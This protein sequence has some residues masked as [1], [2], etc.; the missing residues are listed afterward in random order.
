MTST[1]AI[2]IGIDPLYFLMLAPA[3]LLA[4]WAQWRVHSAFANAARVP[5]ASGISGAETAHMIMQA[6]GVR[7]VRI[8]LGQGT[9]SDHYDPRHKVVRLSPDVYQGRSAAALGI[10]AHE[11]GHVMQEKAGYAPLAIRN[12]IVPLASVGGQLGGLVFMIGFMLSMM[13]RGGS[14]VGS[15]LMIGA[16]GLFSLFVMFQLINLP[17]E[18][19]ASRRAKQW[20]SSSGL[21]SEAEAPHVHRVL[22]AAAWTYVAATLM[23][24]LTLAYYVLRAVGSRRE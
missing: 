14:P 23:A 24:I 8:E 9:L 7:D 13:T 19:D 17:V 18:F 15:W 6:H 11:I 4:M 12:G 16:I 10:A 3:M 22:N 5:V 20:L 2:F 21:V 1:L